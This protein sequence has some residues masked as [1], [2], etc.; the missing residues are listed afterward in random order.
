MTRLGEIFLDTGHIYVSKRGYISIEVYSLDKMLC[1]YVARMIGGSVRSHKRIYKVIMHNRAD[2]AFAS[3]KLLKVV[4]NDVVE[5][6]LQLVVEYANGTNKVARDSTVK[7]LHKLLAQ[8][9]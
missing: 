2:L 4:C 8:S 9:K 6:Q 1:A 7:E 3:Q 5:K